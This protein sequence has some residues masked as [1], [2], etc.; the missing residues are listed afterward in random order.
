MV[1]YYLVF[2][3]MDLYD[4]YVDLYRVMY[5]ASSFSA[6]KSVSDVLG[7][8]FGYSEKMASLENRRILDRFHNIYLINI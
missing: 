1:L 4:F 5:V 3:Y 2:T 6:E 8:G 7:L